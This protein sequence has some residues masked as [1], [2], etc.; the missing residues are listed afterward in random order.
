MKRGDV[1]GANIVTLEMR[2]FNATLMVMSLQ[3]MYLL[4][5]S[6][7]MWPCTVQEDGVGRVDALG[8]MV[9]LSSEHQILI[10]VSVTFA[11][12]YGLGTMTLI[13]SVIYSAHKEKLIGDKR[14]RS[15]FP[16]I[17][18]PYKHSYFYWEAISIAKRVLIIVGPQIVSGTAT[19]FRSIATLLGLLVVFLA[20]QL[21]C[22][23]F[24]CSR[25]TSPHSA[26]LQGVHFSCHHRSRIDK[27]DCILQMLNITLIIVGLVVFYGGPS[28]HAT[29]LFL[30]LS[31]QIAIATMAVYNFVAVLEEGVVGQSSYLM[32]KPEKL[33]ELIL[34][35]GKMPDEVASSPEH[36]RN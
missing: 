11:C 10:A 24:R 23:P 17:M 14:Y 9:C 35:S 6:A 30:Q 29:G 8:D 28:V 21:Y 13:Y 7:R 20:F 33:E 19:P 3:F 16:W 2:Y 1:P 5:R 34:E 15:R 12:L 32:T 26:G 22:K 36:A 25:C 27:S 4:N 31:L 18:N